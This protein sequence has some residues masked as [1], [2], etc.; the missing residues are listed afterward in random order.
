MEF[1]PEKT[2]PRKNEQAEVLRAKLLAHE[3]P[4]EQESAVKDMVDKT[5]S[6]IEKFGKLTRHTAKEL[7]AFYDAFTKEK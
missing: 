6:E 2:P 4:P 1:K 3:I 7:K 5:D